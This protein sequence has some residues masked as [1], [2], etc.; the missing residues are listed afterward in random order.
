MC[1]PGSCIPTEQESVAKASTYW[2]RL[3]SSLGQ[4]AFSQLLVLKGSTGLGGMASPHQPGL[5]LLALL[6]APWDCLTPPTPAPALLGQGVS[7][8]AGSRE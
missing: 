7:L 6:L 8:A 5:A 1:V 2:Y 4:L 3:I